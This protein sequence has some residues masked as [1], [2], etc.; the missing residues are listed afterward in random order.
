LK[1][2]VGV[3]FFEEGSFLGGEVPLLGYALSADYSVRDSEVKHWGLGR[4]L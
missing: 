1:V 4:E 3:I 2:N